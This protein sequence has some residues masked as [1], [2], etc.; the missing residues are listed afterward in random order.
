MKTDAKVGYC[1]GEYALCSASECKLTGR[2]IS[3]L[4]P[5]G[6]AIS[7]EVSCTCPVINDDY[8]AYF[9]SGKMGDT[10]NQ[11]GKNKVWS[12]YSTNGNIP[13]KVNNWSVDPSKTSVNVVLCKAND[14]R[15]F[16]YAQCGG[17]ICNKT[18]VT[19]TGVQLAECFCPLESSENFLIQG[20]NNDESFCSRIKIAVPILIPKRL[21]NSR[22]QN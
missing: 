20:Y 19:E 13:Q 16:Y 1:A 11:P 17:F 18:K 22:Q 7:P 12:L 14:K 10:C 6:Q 8:V 3:Y 15:R 21:E 4:S 2:T 9:N 5:F